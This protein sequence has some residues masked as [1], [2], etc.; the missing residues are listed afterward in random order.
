[1]LWL[2]RKYRKQLACSYILLVL[3]RLDSGLS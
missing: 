3:K 2:G 1:M